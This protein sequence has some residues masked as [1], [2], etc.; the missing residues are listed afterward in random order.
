MRLWVTRSQPGA[1]RTAEALRRMGHEPV[2]QPALE[3]QLD[4]AKV[5]LTDAGA[6]AFT[7]A[8]AVDAFAALSARR[9][10]PVFVTGEATEAAA[11]AAG[12]TEVQSAKG[13]GRDLSR[14]IQAASPAGVIV[15]PCAREPAHDLVASLEAVGFSASR[16]TVYRTVKSKQPPPSALDGVIIHS[17]RAASAVAGVLP[18]TDALHLALFT[19]SGQAAKPLA[20]HPFASVATAPRPDELTLLGLIAG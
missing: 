12:F 5:D 18:R 16:Q 6:L 9:D 10:L 8:H 4:R 7:S 14:L 13:D 19:I 3:V 20:D 15:W 17:A 11:R 2:V 1:E